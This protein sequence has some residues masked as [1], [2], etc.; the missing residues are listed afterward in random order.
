MHM[1]VDTYTY[2]LTYTCGSTDTIYIATCVH[3]YAYMHTY[4]HIYVS[5]YAC[6]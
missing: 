5:T 3:A 4:M 1:Y 6:T 2:V